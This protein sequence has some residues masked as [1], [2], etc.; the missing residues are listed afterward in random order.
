M[1]ISA[2]ENAPLS[3]VRVIDLSMQLPG[4]LTSL[5]LAHAGADVVKIERPDQGDELRSAEPHEG[6]VSSA[7]HLLNHGKTIV[8]ADLKDPE[9][10]ER[11]KAAARSAEVMIE[12][13]RPGVASR[14]GIGYEDIRA[15]N[16]QIVYCSITG[17]G[18]H[19][20]HRMRAGHDL[21]YLAESGRLHLT[22]HHGT[23]TIPPGAIADIAGGSYPAMVSILLALRTAEQTG[24]GA[25]LDIS[26]THRLNVFAYAAI[27]ASNLTGMWPPSN[28]GMYNGGS[29]RYA[30]YETR[31]GRYVAVAAVED[32]FWARLVELLSLPDG[33]THSDDEEWVRAQLAAAISHRSAAEW[34]ELF[35]GADVCCS[36]VATPEEAERAGMLNCASDDGA[37]DN[38][39]LSG[40]LPLGPTLNHHSVDA[41]QQCRIERELVPISA[42]KS[43]LWRRRGA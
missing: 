13:F 1:A 14:L 3:G 30:F 8:A 6:G 27:G 23:P 5:M 26:M 34:S 33:A 35:T 37:Y 16:P 10:R 32:R 40:W 22:D 39:C 7:Y 25:H 43:E 24:Q 41:V 2:P 4:P 36:V 38:T 28:S 11:V 21:N 29:P 17:Y 18:Q 12:Q 9:Q 42:D 15:I 31:D 20:P 19:G